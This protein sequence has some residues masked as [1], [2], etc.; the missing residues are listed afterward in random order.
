MQTLTFDLAHEAQLREPLDQ[1]QAQKE[2]K[3]ECQ[4]PMGGGDTSCSSAPINTDRIELSQNNHVYKHE[5]LQIKRIPCS[6]SQV[7]T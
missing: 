5:L 7:T 3:R 2:E 6:Q 1:R 4:Q